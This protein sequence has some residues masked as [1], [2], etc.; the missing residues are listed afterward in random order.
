MTNTL[1]ISAFGPSI[2]KADVTREARRMLETVAP[3]FSALDVLKSRY[4]QDGM[5]FQPVMPPPAYGSRANRKD[6]RNQYTHWD[7]QHLLLQRDAARRV[8]ETDPIAI[9]VLDQMINF[10][11]GTGLTYNAQPK[12]DLPDEVKDSEQMV[13]LERACNSRIERFW[14]R[15]EKSTGWTQTK[16]GFEAEFI[17]HSIIDGCRGLRTFRQNDGLLPAQVDPERIRQPAG[18]TTR[19]FTF[20]GVQCQPGNINRRIGYYVATVEGGN[21]LEFVPVNRLQYYTRN[22]PQ[23]VV[24]GVSDLFSITDDLEDCGRAIDGI[25]SGVKQRSKIAVIRSHENADN[26]SLEEFANSQSVD[27]LGISR[28]NPVTGENERV[29]YTPDGAYVDIGS[30]MKMLTMPAGATQEYIE[31]VKFCIYAL[32]SRWNLPEFMVVADPGSYNY[33]S[34]MVAGGPV[35]RRFERE[36]AEF[37]ARFRRLILADLEYAAV[38]GWLPENVLDLIDVQVKAPSPVIHNRLEEVQA[39]QI[40]IQ[41]GKLSV[42]TAQQMRG[43]DPDREDRNRV[44]WQEKNPQALDLPSIG[45]GQLHGG[46]PGQS[47]EGMPE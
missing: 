27:L 40:E 34:I 44:E 37:C 8:A 39:D 35:V 28:F 6:G 5:I 22:V 41:D 13:K 36:Q 45:L 17:R 43:Y 30:T 20:M 26:A 15:Y 33:S 21:E 32:T 29:T 4:S 10:L 11:V 18:K 38:M 23:N 9:G 46:R 16:P 19:D 24:H 12:E 47:T 1:Q 31:G 25:R 2:P 42:Q 14:E 3:W 7:E